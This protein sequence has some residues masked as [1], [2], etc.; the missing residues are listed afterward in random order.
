MEEHGSFFLMRS[1]I[2]KFS[3]SIKAYSILNGTWLDML[4]VKLFFFHFYLLFLCLNIELI[5]DE[6]MQQ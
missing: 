1:S 2:P 4:K 5:G 6:D 3:F